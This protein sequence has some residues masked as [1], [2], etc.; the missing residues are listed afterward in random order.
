MWHNSA[1]GDRD[2]DTSKDKEPAKGF[3]LWEQSIEETADPAAEP[4]NNDVCHKNLP[5]LC[6]EVRM[7][8]RVH[9]DC[10]GAYNVVGSREAKDPC[11]E[12]P[13]AS[14][15]ATDATISSCC[16]SSPVVD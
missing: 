16:D 1:H 7:H 3:N 8:D 14:E 10:L 5:P 6:N 12:I 11:K 4:G 15:E 2:E 13:P 9:R